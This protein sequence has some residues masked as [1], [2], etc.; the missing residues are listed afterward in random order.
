[1]I[2]DL[3]V[4]FVSTARCWITLDFGKRLVAEGEVAGKGMIA[5]GKRYILDGTFV[6]V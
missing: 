5:V 2:G 1:V 6:V 3:G 4:I